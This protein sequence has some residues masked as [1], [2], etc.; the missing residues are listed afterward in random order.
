MLSPTPASPPVISSDLALYVQV[1]AVG[2]F[3]T[4][5]KANGS[6][7]ECGLANLGASKTQFCK[8]LLFA[9]SWRGMT[10]NDCRLLVYFALTSGIPRR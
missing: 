7:S 6:D 8:P 2:L 1:C 5:P 9:G 10:R 4:M 3:S